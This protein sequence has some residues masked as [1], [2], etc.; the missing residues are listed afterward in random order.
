MVVLPA[1][2]D[3]QHSSKVAFL[4][5]ESLATAMHF[6]VMDKPATLPAR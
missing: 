6:P 5:G 4:I 1:Q 2:A 3:L